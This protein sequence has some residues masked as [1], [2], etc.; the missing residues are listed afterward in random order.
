MKRCP[1]CQRTYADED[2][3]FCRDDGTPLVPNSRLFGSEKTLLFSRSLASVSL[4]QQVPD[5][6]HSIAVLPFVNISADPENDYFCDGLAEELLN[7]L[8][9]IE[10]LKV[11]AR[12]SAF[13]FKGKD[14]DVREIGRK[15]G[16]GV[17]LEG[18]VR[19]ADNQLRITAQL[20]DAVDGYR[21]WSE[22]YDRRLENVFG[23][24]DEISLAIV[25][26]L[27]LK[28]LGEHRAA[29]LKKYTD[30]AEAYHLYLKGRYH[31]NKWTGDGI[32]KSVEFFNQ[33]ITID[34]DYALAHAGL[35]DS[36]ANLGAP[37]AFHLSVTET[38]PIAKA[39]AIRALAIDNNLAEAHSSLGLVKLNFEWDW[40]GAEKAFKR[41]LELN[42]NYASAYHWYSHLLIAMARFDES[43]AASQRALELSPLDLEMN[44]HLAWHYYFARDYELTLDIAQQTLEMDS[45]FAEP[46][47]FRGWACEQEGRYDEAIAAY[48]QSLIREKQEQLAWLG[49]VYA[50]SGNKVEALKLLDELKNES[51]QRYISPYW[52]A[53]IYLG[54]NDNDGTFEYLGKA[55]D[56]RNAWLVYLNVNPI[57]DSLRSDSRFEDLL[58]RIG[59]AS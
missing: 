18:S 8:A 45:T 1:T 51:N 56:E 35:A 42:P 21:L 25:E 5:R 40:D 39:A 44:I 38:A 20:I 32:R 48:Q 2:V 59:L 57:F 16:V 17:V 43:L 52:V 47:W 6:S 24:Q 49:H 12:T 19:K 36:Y 4:T 29:L 7:A 58:R 53:I 34:P 26:G 11:A 15:L 54:L 10:G 37:N 30:N 55:F 13:S 9:K 33:A 31:Q 28:L 41:A 14:V 50:I 3:R 27:K 23:I 22:R 46:H